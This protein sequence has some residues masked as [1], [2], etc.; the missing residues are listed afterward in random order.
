MYE[1]I[2][3]ESILARMLQKIPS[4]MDKREGSLIY[5]ALAPCAI[6]LQLMYIELDVILKETFGDTA[7]REYLIRRA[8]ERG[9]S[10][11]S[12]TYAYLR[13][14][15]DVEVA[16]GTR[17]SCDNLNYVV[18]QWLEDTAYM[19]QCETVGS[20]GNRTFGKLIPID[21]VQ[22]LTAATL[23]DLLIP[24]EDE[25]DT[26]VFRARYL[27]SFESKA[28]GGNI[29]DYLDKT[30]AIPG[31]GATKVTP[32]WDGGG[33]VKL[34]ILDAEFQVAS[35]QLVEQVQQLIDPTQDGHGMGMTPIGHVVTV[36]TVAEYPIHLLTSIIF[37]GGYSFAQIQPELEKL[38]ENYLATLRQQWATE[39]QLVV[40]IAQIEAQIMGIL[41]VVDITNTRLNGVAENLVLTPEQL[42]VKGVVGND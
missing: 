18:T 10:P 1:A 42:P 3:F 12:A 5:D 35:H 39:A 6:E 26:E 21:Y 34:T 29:Q 11:T 31:V 36:T 28:F 22:D 9:L 32:V 37:E 2:T 17:F 33:T 30:N 13:G 16:L 8:L 7:S 38:L 23:T 40:R 27:A 25:E 41:G 19:L 15:F 24:G 20:E 14:E 4:N